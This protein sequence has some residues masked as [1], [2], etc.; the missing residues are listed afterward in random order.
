[1]LAQDARWEI[2]ATL[3]EKGF[4]HCDSRPDAYRGSL[5]VGHTSVEIEIDVVDL[6]FAKF[7]K[8]KL[9]SRGQL[10]GI[11]IAH[12]ETDNGICYADETLLRLDSYQPGASV[13]R[14][15]EEVQATILKSFAG[16]SADEIAAEYQ[17][18]WAGRPLQVVFPKSV[19]QTKAFI[20]Q[21]IRGSKATQPLVLRRGDECPKGYQP[22][23]LQCLVLGVNQQLKPTASVSVPKTLAELETW[24]ASQSLTDSLAFGIIFNSLCAGECV[25]I[26]AENAWL[27]FRLDIPAAASAIA[28]PRPQFISRYLLSRQEEIGLTRYSGQ[29]CSLTHV[30]SRCL[31][32]PAPP[33]ENKKIAIVGCGTVGSHIARFMV[34]SGAGCGGQLALIDHDLISASNLGRHLLNFADIGCAKATAL[35]HD[36]R[37]FHP[38]VQIKAHE[39]SIADAWS[40]L[41]GFDLIVDATGIEAVGDFMNAKALDMRRSGA[42]VALLHVWLFGNGIAAQT[43]LNAGKGLAC[44]RCLRPELDKAWL[45]DPRID[46]GETGT[47]VPTSCGDGAYLPYSVDAPVRAACIALRAALDF[48]SEQHG[49]TLRTD[50]ID[51]SSAKLVKAKSPTPHVRCP[52]CRNVKATS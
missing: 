33:L 50:R 8:V 15:L 18:Y 45:N 42:E 14:V 32:K 19:G 13:L 49:P 52:A 46:S 39:S 12:L 37:R 41:S 22:S 3:T 43:F 7:P 16:R 36:L 27:G 30:T 4:R 23:T 29:E 40:R 21:P 24:Y 31:D 17:R 28:N 11:Q 9:L 51:P 44:Y 2:N 38:D 10:S 20:A 26:L 6:A 25:L 48:F 35:A 47:I 34:Q 1:M 5:R